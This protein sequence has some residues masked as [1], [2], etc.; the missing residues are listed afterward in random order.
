MR[1]TIDIDDGIFRELKRLAAEERSTLRS[2]IEDALRSELARR[3]SHSRSRDLEGVVT[4]KGKGVQPGVNLDSSA[5]LL[6]LMEG[7]E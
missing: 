7:R 4:F 2:V 6:D 5:D 1:T 3:Q